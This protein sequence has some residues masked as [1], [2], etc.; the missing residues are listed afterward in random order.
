M[1]TELLQAAWNTVTSP[2]LALAERVG[3]G[4]ML[5][6]P[7]LF[8]GFLIVRYVLGAP[9]R[10]AWR[11]LAERNGW[12]SPREGRLTGIVGSIAWHYGPD[13]SD[14]EDVAFVARG[15]DPGVTLLVGPRDAYERASR[16]ASGGLTLGKLLDVGTTAWM[17]APGLVSADV[18]SGE[19]QRLFVVLVTRPPDAHRAITTE[20]ERWWLQEG[21]PGFTAEKLDVSVTQGTVRVR[22]PVRSPGPDGAAR[23]VRVGLALTQALSHTPP[24]R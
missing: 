3:I 9:R 6:S 2:S 14:H 20:L 7:A 4:A 13:G 10:V 8:A 17:R 23:L 19:F 18:G 15:V 12:T 5:A 16:S 24:S 11:A 21:S 22:L 1:I